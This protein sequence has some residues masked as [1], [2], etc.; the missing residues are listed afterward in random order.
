MPC[1]CPVYA[2][3]MPCLCPVYALSMPCLC[4]VYFN[5]FK[6]GI[7][8]EAKGSIINAWRH[9]EWKKRK[10]LGP[11][12]SPDE[13]PAKKKVPRK[14]SVFIY[15]HLLGTFVC[16]LYLLCIVLRSFLHTY[17]VSAPYLHTYFVFCSVLS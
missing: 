4:P 7:Y 8:F 11:G 5:N 3:S 2:L 15:P 6:F 10:A 1:V 9:P 13:E 17:S 14:D 16:T 12:K